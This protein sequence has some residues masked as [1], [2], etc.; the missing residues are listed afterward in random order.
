MGLSATPVDRLDPAKLE[1]DVFGKWVLS[2]PQP[3]TY[4]GRPRSRDA[5][6]GT[7][8][9]V[10]RMYK[11]AVKRRLLG[12]SQVPDL[13][14]LKVQDDGQHKRD[15]LTRDEYQQ[16]WRWMQDKWCRGRTLQR[17]DRKAKNGSPV[18]KMSMVL[19]G[20]EIHLS[21]TKTY[22]EECASRN[23]LAL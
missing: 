1:G 13:E 21:L 19:N 14:Y 23:S 9:Q 3:R 22:A 2:R 17:Y 11:F 6:N 12:S 20:N 4:E 5:V 15:I 18:V 7:I 16:L 8:S 10:R